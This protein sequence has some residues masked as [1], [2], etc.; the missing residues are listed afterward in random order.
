MFNDWLLLYYDPHIGLKKNKEVHMFIMY[1]GQQDLI[2]HIKQV[3]KQIVLF[4]IYCFTFLFKYQKTEL[5]E[6]YI[7]KSA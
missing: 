2:W 5:T 1:V 3:Q 6:I 4:G 7:K